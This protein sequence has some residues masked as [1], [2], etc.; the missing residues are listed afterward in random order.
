M[1]EDDSRASHD[2]ALLYAPTDD[3]LGARI[4]R[5]RNGSLETGEI[6]PAKE[7]A[8]VNAGELVRLRP[9]SD[10]PCFCDVEVLYR[11][12]A[13]QPQPKE[14]APEPKATASLS[15]PAQVATEQYRDNWDRIFGS[16]RRR[17]APN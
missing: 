1:A 11:D 12:P 13:A 7:G 17:S 16:S 4:V 5:A 14:A 2:V 10:T 6:R 8:P 15:G 9:R 3:G